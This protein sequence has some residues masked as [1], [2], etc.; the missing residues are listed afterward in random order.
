[1]PGYPQSIRAEVQSFDGGMLLVR[2]LTE[3]LRQLGIS[4]FETWWGVFETWWDV[5]FHKLVAGAT[6]FEPATSTVTG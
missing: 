6:G 3:K 4:V 5:F 2:D 1:M